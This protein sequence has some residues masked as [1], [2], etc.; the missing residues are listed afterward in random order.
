MFLI[1]DLKIEHVFKSSV[2]GENKKELVIMDVLITCDVIIKREGKY[3]TVP[4]KQRFEKNVLAAGDIIEDVENAIQHMMKVNEYWK[5]Q[6]QPLETTKG[7]I[8][9][10]KRIE[11]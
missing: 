1:K 11:L 10:Q 3:Y 5:V 9:G 4:F 8:A 7:R 6:E 2:Y